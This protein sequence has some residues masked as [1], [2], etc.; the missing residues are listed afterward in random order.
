MFFFLLLLHSLIEILFKT[1]QTAS[2]AYKVDEILYLAILHTLLLHFFSKRNVLLTLSIIPCDKMFNSTVGQHWTSLLAVCAST[3]N[4]M[5]TTEDYPSLQNFNRT[6]TWNVTIQGHKAF[7]LNFTRAGLRQLQPTEQCQD[8]HVY[9]FS[10]ATATLG[11]FCHQG[12]I[13][14]MEVLREGS[15]SLQVPG[16]KQLNAT[17]FGVSI[18]P[19]IT[20]K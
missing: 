5:I 14:S 1:Y 13:K 3:C 17:S 11:R 10:T 4:G 8:K 2:K 20:C 7:C 16:K 12:S 9:T 15:V 18:G 19:E 6:F